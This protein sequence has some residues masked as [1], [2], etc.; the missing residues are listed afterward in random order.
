MYLE[1]ESSN[2]EEEFV[3]DRRFDADHLGLCACCGG[4]GQ[5]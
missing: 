3:V 4:P 1:K 5:G 2:N